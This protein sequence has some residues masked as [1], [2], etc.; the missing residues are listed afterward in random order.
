MKI[1]L[2]KKIV[3][4]E[5]LRLGKQWVDVNDIIQICQQKYNIMIS[6][7]DV[8]NNDFRIYRTY[9]RVYIASIEDFGI[10]YSVRTNT[11]P[12]DFQEEAPIAE[13]TSHKIQTVVKLRDKKI[14]CRTT[15][16]K[17]NIV[18]HQLCK[19]IPNIH[20]SEDFYQ[21]LVGILNDLQVFSPEESLEIINL[22]K[23]FYQVYK[24]P[25]KPL[26]NNLASGMKLID[27]L[28]LHESFITYQ[29]NEEWKVFIEPK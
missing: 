2:I 4:S 28:Q 9:S 5:S 6:L 20:N 26:L 16:F 27:F 19:H 3:A 15:T 17:N 7:G 22:C 13:E 24:Q 18:N 29:V 21:A 10:F 1:D 14:R 23:Y 25:V 12:Q 8:T 11:V